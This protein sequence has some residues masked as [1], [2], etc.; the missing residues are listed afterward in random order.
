MKSSLVFV[1]PSRILFNLLFLKPNHSDY[2]S[3]LFHFFETITNSKSY[4]IK[5]SIRNSICYY[6]NKVINRITWLISTIRYDTNIVIDQKTCI[7]FFIYNLPKT[8]DKSAY[9]GMINF[10]FP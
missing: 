5:N 3:V 2:M 1:P 4:S 7:K 10:S 6:R 9:V 8:P